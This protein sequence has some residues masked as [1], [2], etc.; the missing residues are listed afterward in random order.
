MNTDTFPKIA[1]ALRAVAALLDEAAEGAA[2][3]AA[4]QPEL[5]VSPPI[6]DYEDAV[7][8]PEY[9]MRDPEAEEASATA[10]QGCAPEGIAPP[11]NQVPAPG[12]AAAEATAEESSAV[13]PQPEPQPEPEPLQLE[14]AP[15]Q[16]PEP[17]FEEMQ[18]KLLEV[19]RALGNDAV[20]NIL[21]GSDAWSAAD[22]PPWKRADVIKA[23]DE[24][25]VAD[26]SGEAGWGE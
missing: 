6:P 1:E 8:H 16:E 21:A 19:A 4:A 14:P 18:A 2:R 15:E 3:A 22:V 5:P 7:R 26:E 25:I 24:A 9:W 11:E 13:A 20:S 17:S 10:P 12:A 23:C